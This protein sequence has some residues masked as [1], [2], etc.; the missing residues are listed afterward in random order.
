MYHLY[1]EDLN[2]RHIK[3]LLSR[4]L[5]DGPHRLAD[6]VQL[7]EEDHQRGEL[8]LGG[9]FTTVLCRQVAANQSTVDEMLL[10]NESVRF[11]G[12]S[13]EKKNNSLLYFYQISQH[14]VTLHRSVHQA[15]K[16]PTVRFNVK[17]ATASVAIHRHKSHHPLPVV[18]QNAEAVQRSVI[19]KSRPHGDDLRVEGLQHD[20]HVLLVQGLEGGYCLAEADHRANVPPIKVESHRVV[21][22]L[23]NEAHRVLVRK[24]AHRRL[25]LADQLQFMGVQSGALEENRLLSRNFH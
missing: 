9:S 5:A 11:S 19:E 18:D 2:Q 15:Q 3:L 22:H 7:T 14:R 17:K 16:I 8:L 10:P 4:L 21:V 25:Q 23:P 20:E 1:F 12:P 13:L 24:D 6:K